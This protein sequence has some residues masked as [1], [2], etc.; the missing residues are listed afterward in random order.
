M[1][2]NLQNAE[3][4]LF[5]NSAIKPVLS[6]LRHIFDQW[7]FSYRFPSLN[8]MRKQAVIDLLNSLTSEHLEKLAKVFKEP[9]FVEKLDYH[10]V[11]NLNLSMNESLNGFSSY[12]N[13]A[14]DRNADT[15]YVTLWR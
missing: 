9:V 7:L 2:I 12:N 5:E 11:K 10:T 13:I 4:L 14:I 1:D 8:N 6:D 3:K 15:I